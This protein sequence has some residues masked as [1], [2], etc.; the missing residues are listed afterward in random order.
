LLT[1]RGFA[2]R[3]LGDHG[4][5]LET[6]E[7]DS[8][9]R[10]RVEAVETSPGACRAT[11]TAVRRTSDVPSEEKSRD[12]DLELELVRRLEPDAAARILQAVEPTAK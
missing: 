1:A 3:K 9:T 12:L 8:R 6:R 4:L 11:F 10:C 2:T 7:N 5:V